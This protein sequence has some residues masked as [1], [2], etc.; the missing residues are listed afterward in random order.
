LVTTTMTTPFLGALLRV[1][2]V[3]P[4]DTAGLNTT[5]PSVAR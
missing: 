2:A 5:E 1:I 3:V 4:V